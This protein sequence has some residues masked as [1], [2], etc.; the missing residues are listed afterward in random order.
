MAAEVPQSVIDYQLARKD[1][2][3]ASGLIPF[4]IAGISICA[5]AVALRL[6]ARR[7][8]KLDLK[9]DDWTLLVALVGLP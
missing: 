6:W 7:T 8:A 4:L 9:A 1:E 3:S 2:F 5:V